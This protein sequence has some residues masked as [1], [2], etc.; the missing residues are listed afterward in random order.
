MILKHVVATRPKTNFS[1]ITWR[2]QFFFDDMMMMFVLYQTNTLSWIWIAVAH[3][4]NRNCPSEDYTCSLTPS[5]G[6]FILIQ[7]E[8]VF[9][10]TSSMQH[11]WR[12]SCKYEFQSRLL[13]PNCAG[14]HVLPLSMWAPHRSVYY[15]YNW[16]S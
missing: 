5:L 9:L 11:A 16:N 13:Y 2:Q 12:R 15:A 14:S 6:Q 4:K 1:F 3:C 10:L 7:R 8:P